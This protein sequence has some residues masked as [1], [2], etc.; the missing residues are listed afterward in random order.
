[1]G[2]VFEFYQGVPKLVVPDDTKT[3]SGDGHPLRGVESI[4]GHSKNTGP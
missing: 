4:S 1:M 2:M 3:R